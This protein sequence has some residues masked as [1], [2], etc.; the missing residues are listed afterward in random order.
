MHN[1]TIRAPA[2][3]SGELGDLLKSKLRTLSRT[4]T[5][6][7]SKARITPAPPQPANKPIALSVKPPLMRAPGERV[8]FS[9]DFDPENPLHE[10]ARQLHESAAAHAALLASIKAVHA[11]QAVN[12]STGPAAL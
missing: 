10:H 11:G 7:L 5:N 3:N 12:A 2:K 4:N 1:T 8:N 6:T 9:T